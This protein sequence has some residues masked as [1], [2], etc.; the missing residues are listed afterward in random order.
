MPLELG[1]LY[2]AQEERP[3][4]L[5]GGAAQWLRIAASW[6][7]EQPIRART[8]ELSFQNASK[9][10]KMLAFHCTSRVYSTV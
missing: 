3:L 8:K 10:I 5:R 2:A 4:F 1:H 7:A 6:T 9:C